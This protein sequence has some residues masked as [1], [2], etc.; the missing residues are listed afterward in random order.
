V[1]RSV[2]KGKKM[3]PYGEK[4]ICAV[5]GEK[6]GAGGKRECNMCGIKKTIN[7]ILYFL[8][9]VLFTLWYMLYD[10]LSCVYLC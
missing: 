5:S 2:G 6:R 7:Y 4:F 8:K 3:R 1:K 10:Q 9:W